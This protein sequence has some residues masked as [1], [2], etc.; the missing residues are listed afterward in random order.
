MSNVYHEHSTTFHSNI[1]LSPSYPNANNANTLIQSFLEQ[2]FLHTSSIRTIC[3]T[4]SEISSAEL[5][6][7]NKRADLNQ[8]LLV[9]NLYVRMAKL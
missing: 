4:V 5:H 2:F 3:L 8:K 6:I 7:S 9:W 1:Q